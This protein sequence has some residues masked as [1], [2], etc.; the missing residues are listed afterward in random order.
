MVVTSTNPVRQPLDVAWTRR[1]GYL[2][3]FVLY[4]GGVEV[5]VTGRGPDRDASGLTR[6]QRDARHGDHDGSP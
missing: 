3:S 6:R 1:V 5:G 4:R 2:V